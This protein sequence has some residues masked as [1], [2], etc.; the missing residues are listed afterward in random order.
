MRVLRRQVVAPRDLEKTREQPCQEAQ[1]GAAQ[2]LRIAR[3]KSAGVVVTRWIVPGPTACTGLPLIPKVTR[4][5]NTNPRS[6]AGLAVRTDRVRS[7]T[8][9]RTRHR[10]SH[11]P[12]VIGPRRQELERRE[13]RHSGIGAFVRVRHP[14]HLDAIP[15]RRASNSPT[16]AG[17]EA[18]ARI[19]V[20]QGEPK[21]VGRRRGTAFGSGC[22][23]G[24]V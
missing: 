13:P 22:S 16:I 11:E 10:A 18:Q 17:V 7:L 20:Q 2:V 12:N 15:P 6:Y 1:A 14:L 3:S 5:S 19:R 4:L 9:F 21:S 8:T 24:V 23:A